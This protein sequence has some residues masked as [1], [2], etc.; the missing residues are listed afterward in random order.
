MARDR[1]PWL[2][3]HLIDSKLMLTSDGK[4]VEGRD[5][6]NGIVGVACRVGGN[7]VGLSNYTGVKNKRV[8]LI[9]DELQF[10]PRS[11][12]D[13]IN[14]LDS[15][16]SFKFVGL[17]NT[18]DPTDAHGIICEPHPDEGGWEGIGESNK[19]RTWKSRIPGGRTIQLNGEDSPNMDH[20]IEIY[21]FL[22]GR[23]KLSEAA[24]Y[25]GRD[26]LQYKMMNAGVMPQGSV[27]RRVITRFMAEKHHALDAPIWADESKLTKLV[28]L[29]AAYG[30]I[31]GDRTVMGEWW[32]GPDLR[33]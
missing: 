5:F 1:H 33:G 19:T 21:P 9:G 25:Y 28:G 10:M 7:Y 32:F 12:L 16:P 2:P 20:E 13:A 23:A 26:S 27:A 29:D 31:G 6:R 14:N 4:D 17:A 8:R 30:S 22:I 24:E 3:G 11:F 18:K 15:N